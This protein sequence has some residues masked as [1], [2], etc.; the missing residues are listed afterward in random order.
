MR[1]QAV[2][3]RTEARRQ[4]INREWARLAELQY[5]VG[6]LHQHIT[7]SQPP[8]ACTMAPHYRAATT[9]KY[10][11]NAEPRKFLMS[12]AVAIP[13][14]WGDEATL[15]KSPI[16]SLEDAAANWYSRL[17]PGCIYFWP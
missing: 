8:T 9:P 16:I 4:H 2:V 3:Q 10:H 1:R 13:S 17:P 5:T 15:A 14:A 11:R 12:Y 7:S 6:I